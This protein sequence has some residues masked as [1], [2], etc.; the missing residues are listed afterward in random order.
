MGEGKFDVATT[1]LQQFLDSNPTDNDFL[2][3][4]KKYGTTV[5]QSLRTVPKYSDDPATE[6]K[7]RDNIEELIKRSQAASTK[8]LYNPA[9]V[10]KY[11]RN[12]GATYEERVFA[13]N[14]LRRTG[15]YAIPFMIDAF[16][17]NP[18]KELYIGILEA[19]P[20]LEGHTMAGWV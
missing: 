9:R 12:L 1:F 6:K 14:E 2:E 8:V 3:L 17:K 16:R 19:I 5:F 20:T 7:T 4:E 13:Q 10:E 11:I 15:D 18:E